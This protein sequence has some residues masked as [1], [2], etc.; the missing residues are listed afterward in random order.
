MV[1]AGGEIHNTRGGII[2]PPTLGLMK[3]KVD[4]SDVPAVRR[5]NL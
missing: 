5:G 2:E 4:G 3:V 1:V